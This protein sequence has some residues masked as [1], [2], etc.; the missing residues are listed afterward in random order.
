[1]FAFFYHRF[2]LLITILII[3]LHSNSH[4]QKDSNSVAKK[5]FIVLPLRFT[6]LQNNNTMLSG[7]KLG[8]S[9]TKKI[10]VSI[11]VYHSFYLKSFKSETE[12]IGFTEQPRLFINHVGAEVDFHLIK[13]NKHQLIAQSLL[14]WGFMNYNLNSHNFKTKQSNYFTIEPGLQYAFKINASTQLTLGPGYRFIIG[15]Q[16]IH[17][18]SSVLNGAIPVL[19]QLPNGASIL[20]CL[21]GY[22]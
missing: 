16:P 7:I 10:D 5:W 8:K 6:H 19:T 4:A 15:H 22:L 3:G 13:K 2:H 14:G 11:S 17:F 12:I 20:L 9:V 1:V 21:K 18:T